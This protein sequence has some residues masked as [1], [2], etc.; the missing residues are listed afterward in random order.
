[1]AKR[2]RNTFLTPLDVRVMDS[3]KR[4]MVLHPFT[5]H[6]DNKG[7]P[8]RITVPFGKVTDFASIPRFAR[9]L[10]PKLG[11]WN[12]AAV[13]HD[14]IYQNVVITRVYDKYTYRFTR[15]QADQCFRDGMKASGVKRWQY[16]IMYWAVRIG[17]W[18]S[19]RKR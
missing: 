6:W 2:Q 16:N 19:W 15:K 11:R 5:F 9:W 17:G 7:I 18:A 10:L 8:I 13:I 1:M 4:F 3:G 14:A 12:K